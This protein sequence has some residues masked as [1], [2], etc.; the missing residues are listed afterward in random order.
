MA[1]AAEA[2]FRGLH[3]RLFDAISRADRGELEALWPPGT[4]ASGTRERFLDFVVRFRPGA[5]LGPS[6]SP[7]IL[8][9]LAQSK[10]TIAMTWRGDFGVTRTASATFVLALRRSGDSWTPEGIHLTAR[11][12]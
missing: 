2:G 6:E 8:G 1:L 5:T 9:D 7:T 10:G 11:F 4:G 3:S 12:P